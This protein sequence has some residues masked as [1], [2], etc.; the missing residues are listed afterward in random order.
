[1]DNIA[2]I[3]AGLGR[4]CRPSRSFNLFVVT[5]GDNL[6]ALVHE[7]NKHRVLQWLV[8]KTLPKEFHYTIRR[9]TCAPQK[10]FVTKPDVVGAALQ[11]KKLLR[12]EAQ[13][14]S[15]RFRKGHLGRGE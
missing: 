13:A 11:L 2:P 1:M 7:V 14:G 9:K 10:E 4:A 6:A 3:L 15:R 8:H 5:L 12:V